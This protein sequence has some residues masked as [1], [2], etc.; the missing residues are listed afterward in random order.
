MSFSFSA[1]VISSGAVIVALLLSTA[2]P[3]AA[4]HSIAGSRY[5]SP[6][7]TGTALPASMADCHAAR[8]LSTVV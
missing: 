8:Y 6:G 7:A 5:G 4:G 1:G 2:A 3:G